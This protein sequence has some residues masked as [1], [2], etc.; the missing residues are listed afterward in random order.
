MFQPSLGTSQAALLAIRSIQAPRRRSKVRERPRALYLTILFF[1][2]LRNRLRTLLG[3]FLTLTGSRIS[4][5]LPSM[6]TPLFLFV[7]LDELKIGKFQSAV[8]SI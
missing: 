8:E 1:S 4:T 2:F 5:R 7:V 6:L 3:P